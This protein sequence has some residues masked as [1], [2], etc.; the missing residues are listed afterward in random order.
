MRLAISDFDV[1]VPQ[2]P[3]DARAYMI[4]QLGVS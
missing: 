2:L 1:F 3:T 4:E